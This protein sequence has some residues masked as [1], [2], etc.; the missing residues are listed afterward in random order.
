M[1]TESIISH[2]RTQSN[3]L[4]TFCGRIIDWIQH[5]LW[6]ERARCKTNREKVKI[7]IDEIRAQWFWVKLLS[8]PSVA[9]REMAKLEGQ[10]LIYWHGQWQ[11]KNGRK[12]TS[13]FPS[14]SH[15]MDGRFGEVSVFGADLKSRFR[16]STESFLSP[17]P[18]S[19][20]GVFPTLIPAFRSDWPQKTAIIWTGQKERS[21]RTSIRYLN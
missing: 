20:L 4:Y 3:G 14:P 12:Q 8:D 19:V 10:C 15:R 17:P 16:P 7:I 5:D 6:T 1:A 21:V 11:D 9:F 2:N 13:G 18:L